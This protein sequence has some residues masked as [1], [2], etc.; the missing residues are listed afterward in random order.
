VKQKL[1]LL[2]KSEN[3]EMAIEL[4]KDYGVGSE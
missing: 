4:A 1:K 3:G 2:E